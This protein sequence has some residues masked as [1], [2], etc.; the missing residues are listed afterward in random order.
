M[1]FYEREP[2]GFEAESLGHAVTASTIANANRQKGKKY[3]PE[4]FMPK[5]QKQK[6]QTV[7]DMIGFAAMMTAAL[8]GKDERA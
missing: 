3:S 6:E 4:D 1:I 2:F 8:G 5:F 7:D